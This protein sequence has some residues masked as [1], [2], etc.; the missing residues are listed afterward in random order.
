MSIM[1]TALSGLLAYQRALA[2]TSHNISNASTEGYSRQ[3]LELETQTPQRLGSAYIGKGVKIATVERMQSDLVDAR[4]RTALSSNADASLRASHAES[5]DE[6]L[7]NE[8]TGLEPALERFFNSVQDVATDPTAMSARTVMLNEADSL[9]ERFDQLNNLFE[10]QRELVNGKIA[11]AVDEINQYSASLVDLNKQIVAAGSTGA[12]P[13]DLLDQRGQILN[14]LSEKIDVNITTQD[15]GSIS[16]FIGN[17]QTL[18]SGAVANP[19]VADHLSADPENLQIGIPSRNGGPPIDITRFMS[20]GE[21]GGLL[22]TRDEMLNGPQNEIGL[23]ALSMT[24]RLN[25]QNRQGFDFNGAAGGDIFTLPQVAVNAKLTNTAADLPA[26]TI[27]DVSQLTPSDYRLSYSGTNYQLRRLQDD[28]PVSM[29][30]VTAG[31]GI[32]MADGLTIDTSVMSGTP[33]V[34]AGDTWLVQPTRFAASGLGVAITDPEAIAA[35]QVSGEEGD[36]RNILAMAGIQTEPLISG[37]TTIQES[38][39]SVMSEVATQTRQAQIARDSSATMLEAAQAERETISGVN[40]DEE[41]ANLVRF[42]QAYQASA[43]VIAAAGEMFDTLI[44][45]VR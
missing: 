31:S 28:T 22:E 15:D 10:A 11:N 12:S 27:S 20:G 14:K 7:S 8:T 3:R 24:T 18:V 25:E 42:Q 1:G 17:G 5:I 30:E 26:V 35:A 34:A 29:T 21:I 33:A 6:V 9:V 4:L 44:S 36:N 39:N 43:K 23:I 38:Y 40:L 13:N 37:T 16:V 45:V 32:Y 2:T 19:L 41:A